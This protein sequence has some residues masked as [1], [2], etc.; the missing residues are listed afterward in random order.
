M[1]VDL[2]EDEIVEAACADAHEEA[3]IGFLP[4][5][6]ILRLLGAEKVVID[7][8]RAMIVVD[9]RI[10][11][12]LAVRAP[13]GTA[14]GVL[15]GVGKVFSGRGIAHMQREELRPLVVGRPAQTRVVGRVRCA[16]KTEIGLPLGF[17]VAVE[18]HGF[19]AA[20]ARQTEIDRLLAAR[21]ITEAIAPRAIGRGDRAVIFLD[22][23]AHFREQ[24]LLQVL[25]VGH[26]GLL[27]VVLGF[28]MRADGGIEDLCILED[29]LPVIGSQPGII[30]GAGNAVA[31]IAGRT[32]LRARR[33]RK[34]LEGGQW[35]LRSRIAVGPI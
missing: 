3:G 22:A 16:G 24:R 29:R 10:E 28:Q 25:G 7:M 33:G 27:V 19:F 34:V 4:H 30:V 18:Q 14:A 6:D 12:A 9:G 2:D 31:G 11:E 32:A 8:R 17:L 1:V 23:A 5:H 13:G 20:F 15:D 21:D 35:G 26:R